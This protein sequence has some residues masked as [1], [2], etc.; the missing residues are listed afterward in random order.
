MQQKFAVT[1]LTVGMFFAANNFKNISRA[2]LQG[3]EMS[4]VEKDFYLLRYMQRNIYCTSNELL[5]RLWQ[6]NLLIYL[7]KPRNIQDS[8][9][10]NE[11]WR[12]K[13]FK[14][15]K[16]LLCCTQAVGTCSAF[17]VFLNCWLFFCCCFCF[18]VAQN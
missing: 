17:V 2:Y 15:H 5:Y 4:T 9:D 11:D 10:P 1:F 7:T 12:K 13:H 6:K 14:M 3:A 18:A 8:W 16:S